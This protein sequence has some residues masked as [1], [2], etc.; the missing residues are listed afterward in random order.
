MQCEVYVV[1]NN[2]KAEQAQGF[3]KKYEFIKNATLL[4]DSRHACERF[5]NY[6]NRA[7][8]YKSDV[9]VMIQLG[10]NTLRK[11]IGKVEQ[12]DFD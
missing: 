9:L 3:V 4:S 5:C 2:V 12:L 11:I 6:C 8:G 1:G 10:Q 7:Y